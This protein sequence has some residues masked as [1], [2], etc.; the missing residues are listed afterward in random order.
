[1]T[2]KLAPEV[3]TQLKSQGVAITGHIGGIKRK[4]YWTP[5]GRE[6]YAIPSMRTF[7]RRVGGEIVEEGTRD[8][9]LDKGWLLYPPTELKQYCSGCDRWHD[10]KEEVNECIAKKKASAI[11]WEKASREKLNKENDD[12]NNEISELKEE[13]AEIKTLLLKVIKEK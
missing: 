3:I 5:D 12:V 4:R 7:V 6:V 13:L 2:T 8:A 11:K 10:T 1:M 9:N